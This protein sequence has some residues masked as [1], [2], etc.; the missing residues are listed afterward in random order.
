VHERGADGALPVLRLSQG[1]VRALDH[2]IEIIAGVEDAAVWNGA[3]A[4]PRR[5]RRFAEFDFY[6]MEQASRTA[7]GGRGMLGS[8][9][10]QV[11]GR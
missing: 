9:P 2:D 11:V 8:C 7:R 10:V 6:T 3:I 5:V 1:A 4:A